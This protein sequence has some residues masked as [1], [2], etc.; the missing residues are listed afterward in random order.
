MSRV[1]LRPEA[2]AN[3]AKASKWYEDRSV[4]LGKR[5]LDAVDVALARIDRNPLRYSCVYK[6]VWLALHFAY[7]W[8]TAY[9]EAAILRSALE[10]FRGER[11][12]WKTAFTEHRL[13]LRLLGVKMLLLPLVLVAMTFLVVP[14]L[15]MMARYGL[16]PFYVVDRGAGPGIALG[17]SRLATR[18]RRPRLMWLYAAL[19]MANLAG[20]MSL[21]LG[22]LL[23]APTTLLAWAWI[24][25][26]LEHPRSL[27]VS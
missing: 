12:S 13:V 7:F 1:E 26:A 27:S 15:Y 8:G 10:A 16:A 11:S 21:G 19:G 9:F 24:Y 4:G 2:K 17:L 14:A 5:F 25:L 20:L 3:L 23:S 6:D 22:L 18:G